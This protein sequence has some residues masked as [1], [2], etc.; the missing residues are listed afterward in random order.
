[1]NTD[2]KQAPRLTSEPSAPACAVRNPARALWVA[3][4]LSAGIVP[5]MAVA[6]AGGLWVSGLYRD[7]AAVSAAFRGRDL[8][9][10]VIAVPIL[11]GALVGAR[12][13]WPT[14]S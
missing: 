12:R 7:P 5:L 2:T 13:R 4:L 9:T 14:A 6:A 11:A 8:V 3:W 10:L 1:M